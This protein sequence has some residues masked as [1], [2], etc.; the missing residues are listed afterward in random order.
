MIEMAEFSV[1]NRR[2]L[3]ILKRGEGIEGDVREKVE[4]I[5][6]GIKGKGGEALLEYVR[7]FDSGV[8]TEETLRVTDDE[9][10]AASE[11]VSEEFHDAIRLAAQNIE[12]FHEKQIRRGYD[13]TDNDG[14]SLGKK[15][16]PI[17]RVGIYCPAGTAPLFSSLLMNT[18]PAQLAGVREIAVAIPPGKDGNINPYMLA[19]ARQLGLN[20]IYKMGGAHAIG[21]FAYGATPVRRVD[22]IVGPGNAYVVTAK[23]MVFGA[24]GIDSLAG[25]SEIV[26]IAD[27]SANPRYVAADLLS[28][29]EHGS[30]HESAVLL[31]NDRLLAERVRGEVEAVMQRLERFDAIRQA[32]SRYGA[33]FICKDLDEAVDVA[34]VIAPEHLEIQ[35]NKPRALLPRVINAGAVFLGPWSPE[36][37]GD[38][39]AGTNHVL[40]TNGAARFSSSL[41]VADFQ[42][43]ISIIDYSAQRLRQSAPHITLMARKEQLTA[44]AHAVQIRFEDL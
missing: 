32:L 21:A 26:I 17:S 35:T 3:E 25:P 37:V 13:I 39:F 14:V 24:V 7:R 12:R 4:E 11:E 33:I 42:K 27:S 29:V 41:G 2:F 43:D 15:V 22:K 19:T 34:N 6:K 30:G 1:G 40:P 23:R 20:E 16:L 5:L 31:T 36:P 9:L 44:H 38:Y 10:A 18:I 8:V 28:Q